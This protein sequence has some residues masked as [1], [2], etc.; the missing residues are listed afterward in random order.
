MLS[1]ALRAYDRHVVGFLSGAVERDEKWRVTC[2]ALSE[3]VEFYGQMV[4][5]MQEVRS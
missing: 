2:R 5:G 1:A 3:R 4:Y